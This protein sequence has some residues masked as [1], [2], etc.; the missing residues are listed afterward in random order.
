LPHA[1]GAAGDFVS[2]LLVD[3]YKVLRSAFLPH[4]ILD[5]LSQKR[6]TEVGIVAMMCLISM[7][8]RQRVWGTPVPVIGK[9]L[10]PVTCAACVIDARVP[11][12]RFEV[13]VKRVIPPTAVSIIEP[14]VVVSMTTSVV[15]TEAIVPHAG[16][17][18]QVQQ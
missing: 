9:V 7:L 1:L 8:S 11:M 17:E 15:V 12:C 18:K 3:L 6:L 5:V 2:R 10:V 16:T 13:R 4:Q 14:G